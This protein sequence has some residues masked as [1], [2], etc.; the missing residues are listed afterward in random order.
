LSWDG[1]GFGS[2]RCGFIK[3]TN[4][5]PFEV[6]NSSTFRIHPPNVDLP[7]HDVPEPTAQMVYHHVFVGL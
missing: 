2:E 3:I 5:K 4:V 7:F 6:S 1:V